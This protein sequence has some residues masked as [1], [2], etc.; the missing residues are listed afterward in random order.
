MRAP[1]ARLPLLPC[2]ERP[3]PM[4]RRPPV[5]TTPPCSGALRASPSGLGDDHRSARMAALALATRRTAGGVEARTLVARM[6]G[7]GRVPV[8]AL[9]RAGE[10]G[11]LEMGEVTAVA[12]DGVAGSGPVL[13]V[14]LNVRRRAPDAVAWLLARGVID[15]RQ[16]RAAGLVMRDR[17][18]AGLRLRL[19]ATPWASLIGLGVRVSG[20]AVDPDA[21]ARAAM[22]QAE[23]LDR[24]RRLWARLDRSQRVVLWEIAVEG[25]A[26]GEAGL[27]L[28]KR[29]EKGALSRSARERMARRA[30]LSALDITAAHYE[31]L[32]TSAARTAQKAQFPKP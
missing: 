10:A 17:D 6:T 7:D 3:Q 8:D 31:G 32:D 18:R 2:R 25:A 15:A 23:S 19:S 28:C 24:L 9:A 22:A 20:G 30:L 13:V 26:L 29:L 1:S 16:A 5:H 14:G 21:A 4:I 11:G 27:A 12:V